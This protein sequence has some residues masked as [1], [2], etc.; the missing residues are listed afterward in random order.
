MSYKVAVI[1]GGPGGYVAAIRAAQLGA[2]VAIIEQDVVGGT[3][4]NRGCIPAKALLAGAA[5]LKG[6]QKAD[7]FGI[8]VSEYNLDYSRLVSRKDAVVKQLIQGIEYLLKRNKIELIKGKGRLKAKGLIEVNTP[9]G[10]KINVEAE[11]I[12]LATGTEPAVIGSFDYNGKNVV[13]SNEAL[14]W[15]DVPSELIIIGGGYI[16]CEFATLFA[17]FGSKVTILEAMPSILPMV[18]SELSRR[19]SRVLKK[20]GVDIKTR[21]KVTDVTDE[22]HKV[23]VTLSDGK[24]L[25]ADKVLLAIGRRFNTQGLGLEDVGIALG[26]KGEIVVDDYFKTNIDGIYAIGDVI[27]KVQLAY[28]ASAQGKAVAETILGKPGKVNFDAVPYTIF[29][30]PEIAGVGLTK[31]AAEEKGLKVKVGKFDYKANGKALCNGETEGMV[32]VIA[33]ASSDRVLGVFLMGSHATELIGEGVLAVDKGMTTE[34]LA[35]TIHAHPTLSECI[36]EAAES[37]YFLSNK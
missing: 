27:N 2:K 36:K 10:E 37:I 23:E 7:T 14:T 24:K 33:D 20:D 5:R 21:V 6:I 25:T 18:D 8:E 29:T 12:I 17:A 3:C 15:Q 28:V 16:G 30:I 4:L 11:N 34:E 19:L 35:N 22:G 1:G 13:T 26:P 32:K 31:E 9:E